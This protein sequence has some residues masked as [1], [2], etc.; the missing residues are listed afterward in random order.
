MLKKYIF[1]FFLITSVA[2]FSQKDTAVV[3]ILHINDLHAKINRF[4][5]LKHVVDSIRKVNNEVYIVAAG[6]L[7]SGNPIVDRYEQ[8]GWPIIDMMNDLHFDLSCL[9]NHDFDYGQKILNDRMNDAKFPFI[10]ANIKTDKAVINQ[11]KPYYL[12][13]TKSGIKIGIIG[14]LQVGQ[15]GFQIL[16]QRTLKALSF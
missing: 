5:Q 7:F 2:V 4:P 14:L 13:T 1:S 8:R 10:C 3:T 15:N 12:L 9:G 11:P 6:D 16:I